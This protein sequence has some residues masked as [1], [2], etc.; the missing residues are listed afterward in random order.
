MIESA[1]ETG[2]RT[3]S[4]NHPA[5]A[6]SGR[7][8]SGTTISKTPTRPSAMPATPSARTRSIPSP[9]AIR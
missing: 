8:V 7:L 1:N 9:K 4:N 6:G 5:I 2:P 3:A